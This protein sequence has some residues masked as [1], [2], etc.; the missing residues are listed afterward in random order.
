MSNKFKNVDIKNYTTFTTTFT[1]TY[2]I[3][4]DIIDIKTWPNKIEID[5]KLCKNIFDYYIE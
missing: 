5:E 2:Y 1:T 4:D 3:F